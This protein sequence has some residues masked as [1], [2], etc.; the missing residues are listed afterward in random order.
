MAPMQP[1]LSTRQQQVMSDSVQAGM[2]AGVRASTIPVALRQL[3]R[4]VCKRSC[5][6]RGPGPK[7]EPRRGVRPLVPFMLL[8]ACDRSMANVTLHG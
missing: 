3:C 5:S 4:R 2:E 1:R 6:H 7:D 8:P